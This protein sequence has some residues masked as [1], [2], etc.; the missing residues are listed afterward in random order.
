MTSFWW[1]HHLTS[2]K[3]RHW[4]DVTKIF[5]F[6]SSTLSKVLVAPLYGGRGG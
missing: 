5:H 4:S 6:K 3:L 1:R 2:P